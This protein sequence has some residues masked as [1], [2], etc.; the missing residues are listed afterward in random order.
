M[1]R[2][3]GGYL[4][5]CAAPLIQLLCRDILLFSIL[6]ECLAATFGSIQLLRP[7]LL[8]GGKHTHRRSLVKVAMIEYPQAEKQM[9]LA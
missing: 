8:F 7:E 6:R 4:F 1:G 3:R 5:Q 2:L 9:Y